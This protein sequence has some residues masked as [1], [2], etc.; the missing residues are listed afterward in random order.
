MSSS[1]LP[2]EQS[3]RSFD[4]IDTVGDAYQFVFRNLHLIPAVMCLPLLIDILLILVADF[5]PLGDFIANEEVTPQWPPSTEF[6]LKITAAL[7][8]AAMQVF[9]L[10]L[11][12]TAWYRLILLGQARAYPRFFY[13]LNRRHLRLLGYSWLVG[14]VIAV[15]LL[16][17]ILL[18]FPLLGVGAG[19]GISHLILIPISFYI[20]IVVP[21]RFSYLFPAV[22]VDE[23]YRLADS[24]RHTRKQTLKLIGGSIL[25]LLPATV[26]AGFLGADVSFGISITFGEETAAQPALPPFLLAVIAYL[27]SSFN[28]LV[29]AAFI[30]I[31]FRTSTGWVPEDPAAD[32][33]PPAT[34]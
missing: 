21:L 18:A 13:P 14:A 4:L 1:S 30:A 9:S 10:V 15:L 34:L 22:A 27:V 28:S 29:M 25:C 7:A 24:W 8:L 6:L 2:P 31:A 23:R 32:V 17:V 12:C 26:A 19:I 3:V 5:T 11:F 20:L 33:A 16:I